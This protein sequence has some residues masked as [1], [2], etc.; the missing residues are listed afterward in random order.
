MHENR[1]VFDLKTFPITIIHSTYNTGDKIWPT[2][3]FLPTRNAL[4]RYKLT[5][6]GIFLFLAFEAML[7]NGGGDVVNRLGSRDL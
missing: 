2:A 7:T 1:S 5:Q 4:A 3:D 6:L